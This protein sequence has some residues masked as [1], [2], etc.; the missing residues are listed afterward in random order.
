MFFRLNNLVQLIDGKNISMYNLKN[1]VV[2]LLDKDLGEFIKY[3]EEN[4]PIEEHNLFF[5]DKERITVFLSKLINLKL[6][7]I[8]SEKVHVDKFKFN[9]SEKLIN[10][11][12][13]P[14]FFNRVILNYSNKC[15]L[16]CNFCNKANMKNWQGCV[17]CVSNY[18]SKSQISDEEVLSIIEK[19]K[20]L[21]IKELFIKGG[22][23]L[24]NMDLIESIVK[25]L[26]EEK[27]KVKII[28]NG[29]GVEYNRLK[30]LLSNAFVELRIVA[31]GLEDFESKYYFN[32]SYKDI[33]K[34]QTKLMDKLFEDNFK[35]EVTFQITDENQEYS[36]ETIMKLREK[37]KT[38]VSITN[39]VD[40]KNP[41]KLRLIQGG[42]K[43]IPKFISPKEIFWNKDHN[44]C[45]YGT[46]YINCDR[47]VYSCSESKDYLGN[48]GEC[49]KDIYKVLSNQ[50]LYNIWN[51]SKD[52]IENC[53]Q[54]S[55]RYFCL[56]CFEFDKSFPRDT[57]CN[58]VSNNFEIDYSKI[59]DKEFIQKI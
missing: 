59:G 29:L 23:P 9:T 13:P 5:E 31:F 10:L 28:S 33:I 50:Q 26:S 27:I 20:P 8:T 36:V 41:N 47:H 53:N 21:E 51:D 57:F 15:N 12:Q 6:G 1:N 11:I 30:V 54:C 4:N 40:E 32:E 43:Y 39:L 44:R 24:M 42:M 38:I 58:I 2:Y 55:L 3:C 19:L 45:L 48:I 25:I 22:N 17:S 52:K 18:D 37:Y 34:G 35:F 7:E 49:G 14:P 46:F 16:D 56:D